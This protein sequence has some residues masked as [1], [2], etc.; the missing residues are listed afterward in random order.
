V[1][2]IGPLLEQNAWYNESRIR[3]I[4]DLFMIKDPYEGADKSEGIIAYELTYKQ[5]KPTSKHE[6]CHASFDGSRFGRFI[7]WI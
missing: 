4:Y 1:K 5:S 2:G 7:I 3:R 6:V